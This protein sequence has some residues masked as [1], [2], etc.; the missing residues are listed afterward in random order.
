MAEIGY[1]EPITADICFYFLKIISFIFLDIF[2]IFMK[3]GNVIDAKN[4]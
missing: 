1:D 4:V 2:Y 3:Y